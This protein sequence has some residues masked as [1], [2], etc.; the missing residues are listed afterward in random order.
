MM[1]LDDLNILLMGGELKSGAWYG[2]SWYHKG[3]LVMNEVVQIPP[4]ERKPRKFFNKWLL[5]LTQFLTL[6]RLDV[7]VKRMELV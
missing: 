3:R 4:D 1:S 6:R 2:V 7:H 5:E